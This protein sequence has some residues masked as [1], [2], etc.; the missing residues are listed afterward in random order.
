MKPIQNPPPPS[1]GPGSAADAIV[2]LQDALLFLIE[3][4]RL[5]VP[6]EEQEA[7]RDDRAH[8]VY[9]EGTSRSVDAFR[10]QQGIEPGEIVDERTAEALNRLLDEL[11]AFESPASDLRHVVSGRVRQEDVE[12]LRGISVRAFDETEEASIRLGDDTTDAEGR[13]TINYE[14]LPGRTGV[15]L[16]VEARDEGGTLLRSSEVIANAKQVEIVNLTVQSEENLPARVFG[17]VR[18]EHGETLDGLTVEAYD[19]DLRS[20]QLLGGS[21]TRQGRYEITYER[22]QFRNA[23]KE[24]AELVIRVLNGEGTELYR[25][26]IYFNAPRELELDISVQGAAYKGPSEWETL[27]STLSPLLENVS[28]LD[29]HEDEQHQD[30]SFLAGE[31]RTD[32]IVIGTWIACFRLADK[33]RRENAALEPEVLFGFLRQGQPSIFHDTLLQDLH[34][35]D[36]ISL[37]EE[38]MLRRLEEITPDLQQSLLEKAI[39]ENIISS[40][41]RSGIPNVLETLRGLKLRY[42]AEGTFGGGKG[43]IGQLLDITPDARPQQAA[44]MEAF[45]SH[46][47]PMSSFWKKIEEDR[48]LEPEVAKQVKLSFELGALSRNHIPLVNELVQRFRRNEITAKRELARYDRTAWK[49][50]FRS[51]GVDGNVIGIPANIDGEDEEARMEEFAAVLERQYERAYPSTAFAAKLERTEQSPVKA[52]TDVVRFLNNNPGFHLD[53]FRV[54]Q[55]VAQNENA[56]QDIEDR[57]AMLTELKSV[58]RIFKLHPTHQVVDALFTRKIDSA[59]QIYFMGQAQFTKAL[60]GTGI[61]KIESKKLYRKAENAYALTLALFGDYNLAFNGL[62]PFAVP[63]TV[64]SAETQAKIATL[65]N[66]Q[67]LFGSLDYCECTHCRSVYSP[68]AYFV[69]IMRYLGERGT[70]G[71]GMHAGKNVSQVILQRRPDLGEIE[72]SCENTNTPL[73]YIDLVNEILEDSVAPPVPLTLNGAIEP[74]LVEGPAKTSVLD[75]LKLHGIALSADARVYSPDSR[76]SWAVRD[77]QHAYA[78]FKTGAALNLLP[79]RQTHLSAA[80]LRANPEHTNLDAY[81]KLKGEVFP[82]S[83]PFDLANFEAR[84]YLSHLGVPQPRLLELFQQKQSDHVTLSPSDLQIDCARLNLSETERQILTGTLPGRQAWEFWGLTET[85]NNI[86]HPENPADPTQN[87]SGNWVDVLSNV[88]VMLHRSGVTYKELLQLVDLQYINPDRSIFIDTSDPN[89][90]NCDTSKFTILNLTAEAAN[91]MHRFIRLWRKFAGPMWELDLLLPDFDP[92]VNVTDK[93]I[94]DAFLQTLSGMN[95]LREQL[96]LDWRV[97]R[98]FYESIDHVISLD[99]SQDGAPVVQTLY[100]RLFRNKLVDAVASF[101]ASPDQVTGTI[102]DKIPGILA[103]FRIKEA[104]LTLILSEPD[105]GVAVTANLDAAMLSRIHRIAVLAQSLNLSIDAFLRLRR[106]CAF[107]PFS[108]PAATLNFVAL[109]KDIAASSFSVLE[110]DYL[111]AHRFTSSSGVPLED[112]AIIGAVQDIRQGLQKISDELRLKSEETTQAYVKSKLGLLPALE[113]DADQGVALSIIDGTWQGTSAERDQLIDT[114]FAGVLDLP[115]AKAKLSAIAGGLSP[116]AFQTEVDKRFDYLQPELEAFLQQTQ[117]ETFVHEKIAEALALEVPSVTI[118]LTRLKLPGSTSILLQEINDPRLL[119]R[120]PDG[121]YQFGLRETDFPGIFR[122]LRL[123]HKNALVIGKLQI[124]T[125]ELTWW[126]DHATAM[127]W[128]DPANFPITSAAPPPIESWRAMHWFFEWK[129][130]LPNADLTAFE[131]AANVLDPAKPSSESVADLARLTGWEAANTETLTKAFHWKDAGAGFDVIKQELKKSV[132]LIRLAECMKTLRRLGVNAARALQ[133]AKA[134]PS[135]ADADSL[136]QTVKAKYD[137]KQWQQV[138]QPIQDAFREQKREALVSWLVAHPDQTKGQNWSDA[139]GLFSYFLIDVEMCACMLTSRLKQAAASVQLFVQRCL[140]NLELDILAKADLDPK[141][142][143]WKWMKQ[144]R[145]WEANRKVFLYP[146]NWLEPELRDEK[147]PFFKDLETELMQNDVTNETAEEAY[148]TYLEKLDKVANLEIRAMYNQPISQDESVLHV[149]ARAR[150]SESPEHFYRRRI[151]NARWTAWEKVDPEIHGNHLVAGVHNRRLYLLW[152]QFLDKAD[153]PTKMTTPAASSSTT[154]A[155]PSK[156]WEIKLFWSELKKGKWTPK[157]LSNSSLLLYQSIAGYLLENLDFRV[158]FVPYLQVRM[159]ATDKATGIAPTSGWL[160]DKLGKQLNSHTMRLDSE[161]KPIDVPIAEH[162]IAP[163]ESQYRN[164]LIQH[165]TTTQYFYYGSLEESVKP[166]AFSPYHN[167]ETIRLLRKVDATRTYSVVD[168]NAKAFAGQGSFFVWDPLHTYFVDY[169]WRREYTYY[170]QAWHA[171]IVS[172]FRFFIHYHPLVELFTKELNIWGMK[173]LL[174]RRIQVEPATIPSVPPLFNFQDYQPDNKNVAS[175]RPVEDVDFTYLGA[176]SLYNWELFF[177]VPFFIANKLSANQRFEEALEWFHYI[178]DPTST[179]TAVANP[180]TPQQK[181]WITKPFYLTTKAD[182]YK[183]KIESI[184]LAIAKGDVELREQVREWRDNPFNP[185]LIAR[186]RTVA[187]Q[188]NVLIKYILTLIAWADQLFRQDTIESINEA[189]QLYILAESIL[190]PRPKSVPRKIANPI[191]TF[192]QLQQEGIDGFGNVLKEVE[193]V[194]SAVPASGAMVDDKPELPYLDVLYF[195]IPNNEKLLTLWDTVADRLFKVRHC[196]NIEGVARQLALFEPPIDPAI[197]VKAVAAGLDIGAVLSDMNAPLPLYRFTFMI[198]RALDICNEVKSLGN[199]MLAALEKRD[200]EALALLRASH[201]RIMLDQVRLIKNHLIDET[202]RT[203]DSLIESK[204]TIE[205]RKAYYEGLLQD[206]LN[207]WESLSLVLTGGVIVS[208]IVGTVLNALGSGTSLIPEVNAGASGFGGSPHVTLT[209]GGKSV[210][211]GL[212][213]AAEVARG[214]ASILQTSAGMTAT[215]GSYNRRAQ[216]W[217][218]QQRLATKELPPIDKQIAAASIRQLIAKQD[219]INQDML[220]ENAQKEDDYQRSKFTHQELYDWMISQ[221]SS[222]Y[223]QSY[224]LAYDIAKRA[225]RCFR[226]ELGLSDSNYI[227]F[228][229]WD[230]LKKGLLAGERLHYDLKRLETAYYE[231]NRRE[232]ELTKHISLEQLDPIALL[233]LRQNGE[234]FLDIPETVFDMDYPSHYFPPPQDRRPVHSLR[235]RTLHHRGLH[236]DSGPQ[237][238]A[239]GLH[240]SGQQVR[241]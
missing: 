7:L 161:G 153:A 239:Q 43:T 150:S 167:A 207:T 241:A 3:K 86:P 172:S 196:M 9:R 199:A 119:A 121:T 92:A 218:Y 41:I 10:D 181:F 14:R 159:Y 191:K 166:H 189:T 30:V 230:S 143:Q 55:Y 16:R 185:H 39:A 25:T 162:I 44:F 186:M 18:N 170:S 184:M 217:R 122:S 183:Q 112:K 13:Y 198:Q 65:P 139:N 29:L 71:T 102:A 1:I 175:P 202:Q 106:L 197:L 235:R 193:N 26:P 227:Q 49:G 201:E 240:A 69:D 120:L 108:D 151:N 224:Q 34:Y 210:T 57:D 225:E 104:D 209:L 12:P 222:V 90:A 33:T 208:E 204:K 130:G 88:D 111:L 63:S 141:W 28:P 154:I 205:E 75:E 149:F 48:V 232:Y 110:L 99:H 152:P 160:F 51:E 21:P 123:L 45:T 22:S 109:A 80:E 64:L 79:T 68:A 211:S 131:F 238:S 137:L 91:R 174:N 87:I 2:N 171:Y 94:T 56:L 157:V 4:G 124:K 70:Q 180:D 223:F 19:R 144:Y 206:G 115:A 237:P 42:A 54:D 169:L 101:P 176:Y 129:S 220:I 83:L 98:S 214:L 188:K 24:S 229:Y 192:Y 140:L 182:Y 36:R 145:L 148:L 20:E 38:K 195:C 179:D 233:K 173:G 61:N 113:K 142:K 100:Q 126:L 50:L 60:A 31:T 95:R 81:S 47:G 234:C 11:G 96:G 212:T 72:L 46:N 82:L 89:A 105:L 165:N 8:E 5:V 231:Q 32:R 132:S 215:I 118:L 76:G 116:A 117:K 84:A 67:T 155:Q 74:D 168:S 219:L 107:D 221:I 40:R 78:I 125:N 177:H 6:R 216:E 35:A 59:Q 178:F 156:Y 62:S 15:N 228:G 127:A 17:M 58:Q 163:P 236:V 27:S 73:P 134:E 158:R 226:Y 164:N 146:E 147:S 128:M 200:A 194:I 85:G 187:Y 97:L 135:S 133:W 66:L 203:W 93:R 136:K 77:A 103:A 190:G 52:K 114:F 213:K 23:D 138:I 37:W 53:R